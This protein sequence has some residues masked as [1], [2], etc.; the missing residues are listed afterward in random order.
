M[1]IDQLY[2]LVFLWNDQPVGSGFLL[3]EDGLIA[4][5]HHVLRDILQGGAKSRVGKHLEPITM[6]SPVGKRFQITTLDRSQR[7][8]AICL[9]SDPDHDVSLLQIDGALP[10]GVQIPRLIDIKSTPM[11]SYTFTVTAFGKIEEAAYQYEYFSTGGEIWGLISR[12]SKA[13]SS[14]SVQMLRLQTKTIL[15]GMSGAPVYVQELDGVVGLISGRFNVD[16]NG[17]WLGEIAWASCINDLAELDLE[18]RLQLVKPVTTGLSTRIKSA[19]RSDH[20]KSLIGVEGLE[21]FIQEHWKRPEGFDVQRRWENVVGRESQIRTIHDYLFASTTKGNRLAITGLPGM[22]KSTLASTYVNQHGTKQNYPGGVLWTNAAQGDG[23]R[24]LS[25]WLRESYHENYWHLVQDL[26]EI[27]EINPADVRHILGGNGRL[28]IILDDVQSTETFNFLLNALPLETDVLITTRE[29]EVALDF[30]ESSGTSPLDL[31]Q[32]TETEATSLLLQSL[33]DMTP[34]DV[35]PLVK[36]V[37]AHPQTLRFMAGQ[38][39]R[40]RSLQLRKRAMEKLLAQI[41]AGERLNEFESFDV[42]LREVYEHIDEDSDRQTQYQRWMRYLGVLVPSETDFSSVMAATLWDTD[43]DTAVEFLE[44][45]SNHFL[46]EPTTSERW[47]LHALVRNGFKN[48]LRE[49]SDEYNSAFANYESYLMQVAIQASKES[50]SIYG[51]TP[52]LPHLHYVV[53][54]RI[55]WLESHIQF[56]LDNASYDELFSYSVIPPLNSEQSERLKNLYTLIECSAN[57]LVTQPIE[58]NIIRRWMAAGFLAAAIIQEVDS[59]ILFLIFWSNWLNRTSQQDIALLALEA[60]NNLASRSSEPDTVTLLSLSEKINIHSGRGE[61]EQAFEIT[62]KCLDLI[63]QINAIEPAIEINVYTNVG[64]LFFNISEF[65]NALEYLQLAYNRLPPD[66]QNYQRLSLTQSISV[67]YT[68][69]GHY[70]KA[71]HFYEES[72]QVVDAININYLHPAMLNNK[73][74]LLLSQGELEQAE[75]V[76]Q[77]SWRLAS[78]ILDRSTQINALNNLCCISISRQEYEIAL[79]QVEEALDLLKHVSNKR[80]EAFTYSNLGAVYYYLGQFEKALETLKRAFQIKYEMKDL[81]TLSQTIVIIGKLY[82]AAGHFSEGLAFFNEILPIIKELKNS[83]SSEITI[84]QWMGLLY[85][86]I[87]DTEQA[88]RL[89]DQVAPTLESLSDP[90]QRAMALMMSANIYHT[91]GR[92]EKGIGALEESLRLWRGLGN[93]SQEFEVLLMLANFL[94]LARRLEKAQEVFDQC[95]ALNKAQSESSIP[96]QALFLKT[97]GTLLFNQQKIGEAIQCFESSAE[98]CLKTGDRTLHVANINNI[99]Y[100]YL[101]TGNLVAAR[102]KLMDALDYAREINEPQLQA[103]IQSNLGLIL[104]MEGQT[105]RGHEM[106]NSAIDLLEQNGL[107]VDSSGQN[108]EQIRFYRDVF[109]QMRRIEGEEFTFPARGALLL[110][111]RSF[112]WDLVE[113]LM[114]SDVFRSEEIARL[115]DREIPQTQD[116]TLVEVLRMYRQIFEWLRQDDLPQVFVRVRNSFERSDIYHWRGRVDYAARSYSS[117]LIRFNRAL[118]LDEYC[119]AYYIDRGWANRGFGKYVAAIND[120]NKALQIE[121]TSSNAYLGRGVVHMERGENGLALSDFNQTLKYN[122]DF[123]LAYEWRGMLNLVL[124]DGKAALNDLEESLRISPQ[125][126]EH[127]YWR[128]ICRLVT[129]D[130]DGA[131]HDL[132]RVNDFDSPD[133]LSMAFTLL[134]RGLAR[135][136]SGNS[137][138]ARGEWEVANEISNKWI[139]PVQKKIFR[140]LYGAMR[141]DFNSA[142][143]AYNEFDKIRYIPHVLISQVRNLRLLE[144]VH[145]NEREDLE[146]LANWL[147][148]KVSLYL[149]G[150]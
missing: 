99:A 54:E 70:E 115:I 149:Y 110:L 45:L 126:I 128:G 34:E 107:T 58:E 103:L 52:D 144:F 142:Y 100:A 113:G 120:F 38:I 94:Y 130:F 17:K 3:H 87:G 64:L 106:T 39:S 134:W 96:L 32:L 148:Q 47:L 20:L 95:E 125:N 93:K 83:T 63:Q 59:Q 35:K 89:F 69:L 5:C 78:D 40:H 92:L 105:D 71:L 22:G 91:Q 80:I 119:A 132:T 90:S 48:Y 150:A 12:S 2:S 118:E 140:G 84:V 41:S 60:I 86:E 104:L 117:A 133:S 53:N 55:H 79:Q 21:G 62:K 36:V 101:L 44:L 51:V 123:D 102:Q 77:E 97:R 146:K 25:E 4:T 1:N 116:K 114:T 9:A 6:E 147:Q 137:R 129:K 37:G 13:Q 67:C 121:S 82:Q 138:Y 7:I 98:I 85:S 88:I 31:G 124:G 136:Q 74:F 131:I 27:P 127:I 108:I 73:G 19:N 49:D 11:G 57:Y 112:S 56:R 76:L 46:I 42:A 10:Q 145:P 30:M 8:E 16:D 43:L 139:N 122:K 81:S 141:I 109:A 24:I 111:L 72:E 14:P 33:K 65:E 66:M 15:P 50:P 135:A 26:N 28:L 18:K 29:R 61:T 23:Q 75:Q 68:E 143:E